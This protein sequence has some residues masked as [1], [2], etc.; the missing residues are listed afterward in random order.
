MPG[1]STSAVFDVA[2]TGEGSYHVTLPP[3][4]GEYFGSQLFMLSIL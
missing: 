2:L 3:S 1:G 4:E